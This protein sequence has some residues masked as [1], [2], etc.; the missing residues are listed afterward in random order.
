M[1]KLFVFL[2]AM[3]L[4]FGIGSAW[5][6]SVLP[7]EILIN[8]AAT[9]LNYDD[10]DVTKGLAYHGLPGIAPIDASPIILSDYGIAEGDWIC[11]QAFG[12]Y[13]MAI[14]EVEAAHNLGGVFS[15]GDVL[16]APN[17][18]NAHRV[19]YAIYAAID[20]YY[21]GPTYDQAWPTDIEQDFLITYE[22]TT[23]QVPLGANY[24]FVA[25]LDVAY[26][27]N[28]DSDSN[29]GLR[30]SP[31]PEPATM[32]LLGSGLIGLAAFRRRLRKS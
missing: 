8:P 1:K 13:S 22:G 3:V 27:D 10:F 25:A 30:I 5:A 9:Y 17:E 19:K 14:G 18:Y 23:I 29:Y 31:V 6:V 28:S 12:D 21:T 4:V 15:L 11:L 20:D 16:F 32:L 7:V 26:W 2:W 24:L